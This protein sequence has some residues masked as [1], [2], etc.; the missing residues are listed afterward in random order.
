MSANLARCAVCNE[1]IAPEH[2]V[3]FRRGAVAG[4][5]Q[6]VHVECTADGVTR[7]L[8]SGMEGKAEPGTWEDWSDPTYRTSLDAFSDL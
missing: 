5:A 8:R 4:E 7:A 3:D 6:L 1:Q 2:H